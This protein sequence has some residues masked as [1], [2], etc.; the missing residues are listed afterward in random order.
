MFQKKTIDGKHQDVPHHPSSV[1]IIT[2]GP[3]PQRHMFGPEGEMP[4]LSS[5]GLKRV[6]STG[7][8]RLPEQEIPQTR[9]SSLQHH[10]G[11]RKGFS[12]LGPQPCLIRVCRGELFHPISKHSWVAAMCKKHQ[13][14]RRDEENKDPTPN[15]AVTCILILS[16][17]NNSLKDEWTTGIKMKSKI[18]RTGLLW[19]SIGKE[20]ACQL[21]GTQA[22]SLVW[23]NSTCLRAPQRLSLRALEPVLGNKRSR[24]NR[25][26]THHN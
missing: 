20:S 23:D 13:G 15:G 7:A 4:C 2:G 11:E 10:R 3:E 25:K 9:G 6:E 14:S 8:K 19:L 18:H 22:G 26:P 24:C 17:N 1:A 5:L 21:Q 16:L 12:S